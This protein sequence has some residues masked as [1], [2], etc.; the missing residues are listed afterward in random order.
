M[1]FNGQNWTPERHAPDFSPLE[2]H[3]RWLSTFCA[4][5]QTIHGR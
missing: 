1:A 5:G 2:F 3:Q 4:D